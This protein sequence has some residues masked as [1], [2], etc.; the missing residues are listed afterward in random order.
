VHSEYRTSQLITYLGNKRKLL[1][2]IE[3]AVNKAKCILDKEKLT[4]FDG[5]SGSGA[6]ARMLKAHSNTLIVNDFEKYSYVFNKCFLTN[7][8]AVNMRDLTQRIEYLNNNKLTGKLQ[9]GFIE[10]LYAPNNDDDIQEGERVFYT[11]IN[12][13]I[14]DN[15]RRQV[16]SYD[17]HC[18]APLLYKAS[19]HNNTSGVFKGFYSEKKDDDSPRLG[20]FG[21]KAENCLQRIKGEITLDIPI[22]SDYECYVDYFHEDTNQLVKNLY[23]VDFAYYDPPYNQHPYGSNYFM[24]NLIADYKKPDVEQIS[25]VSGIPKGWNQSSYNKRQEVSNALD[26]LIKDTPAKIIALSYSSGGFLTQEQIIDILKKYG[27]V[28]IEEQDYVAYRAGKNLR[29]K[30]GNLTRS[31][32]VKEFLFFLEKK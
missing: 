26:K 18:L 1:S 28:S 20:K 23:E 21:G 2:F 3:Q 10:D 32:K 13:K 30:E 12:A 24:L 11:N 5:F 29:D 17:W 14:I 27:K 9:K 22:F 6:V 15:L 16:K 25:K 8:S 4:C 7:R 31:T 19:V